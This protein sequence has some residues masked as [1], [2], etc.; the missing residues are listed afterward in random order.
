ML[1]DH[2]R[3]YK[4]LN[5]NKVKYLVIGGVA[6]AIYGSPRAT[7]DL[8]IVIE[9]TLSNAEALI[10][11]LR[12][13][14]FGTAWLTTAEKIASTDLTVVN[15][16]VKIDILTKAKGIDFQKCWNRRNVKII[17]GVRINLISL[18]DLIGAK[19][20]VKRPIDKYD[21]KILKKLGR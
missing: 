9:P 14:E 16:Y 17:K 21:L 19:K 10:K 7:L 5:K 6:C 2:L 4:S 15:D 12:K 13:A 18:Q 1:K 8:D 11:A 3:L 20:A